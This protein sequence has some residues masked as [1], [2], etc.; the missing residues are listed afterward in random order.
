MPGVLA[1][2]T[3]HDLKGYGTHKCIAPLTNRGV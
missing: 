2:Y 1:V 3:G